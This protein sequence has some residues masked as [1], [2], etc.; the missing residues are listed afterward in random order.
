[1]CGE[2]R[3]Q[4][5]SSSRVVRTK[6]TAAADRG[7][8]IKVSIFF[9]KLRRLHH[10]AQASVFHS[11][12]CAF[13]SPCSRRGG[14]NRSEIARR[15]RGRQILR[16]RGRIREN[17]GEDLFRGGPEEHCKSNHRGYRQGAEERGRQSRVLFRF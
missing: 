15:S 1:M 7:L 17:F 11:G 10:E 2:R 13:H 16:R 6:M 8:A 4:K 3:T 14:P 5:T 9:A 12:I